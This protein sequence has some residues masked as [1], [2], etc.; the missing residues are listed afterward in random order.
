M[1]QDGVQLVSWRHPLFLSHR[2]EVQ[3][4]EADEGC[5][6][7]GQEYEAPKTKA[8]LLPHNSRHQAQRQVSEDAG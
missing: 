6:N 2:R 7:D 1:V 3:K 8:P 5:D 4:H